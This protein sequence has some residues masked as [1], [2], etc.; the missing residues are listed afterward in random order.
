MHVFGAKCVRVANET[1]NAV[2]IAKC[3][4]SHTKEQMA[5]H[6]LERGATARSMGTAHTPGMTVTATRSR[7]TRATCTGR[8]P[9]PA[10]TSV[11]R[12]KSADRGR[13]DR[14]QRALLHC[15]I[16][17]RLPSNIQFAC[18]CDQGASRV[19]V[20]MRVRKGVCDAW[21]DTRATAQPS[22]ECGM[23]KVKIWPRQRQR[24]DPRWQEHTDGRRPLA[25]ARGSRTWVCWRGDG[26]RSR[27]KHTRDCGCARRRELQ[28][29]GA[30]RDVLPALQCVADEGN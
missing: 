22:T 23:G 14:S 12:A 21:S 8:A 24:Q 19:C 30:V 6:K 20:P 29:Q 18:T 2:S 16:C 25:A 3:I 11:P 5:T 17:R 4:T 9:L 28:T 15:Y 26:P 13:A 27:P 7:N 1:Q 10:R